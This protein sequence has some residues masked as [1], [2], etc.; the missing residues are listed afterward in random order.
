MTDLQYYED[1]MRG[2]IAINCHTEDEVIELAKWLDNHGTLPLWAKSGS[3]F[4][5][6]FFKEYREHTCYRMQE[7][8]KKLGYADDF[9]YRRMNISVILWSDI[10]SP[11][12]DNFNMSSILDILKE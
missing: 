5:T 4:T 12:D 10:G 2:K 8:S 11:S 9:F 7:H 1:F 6:T 3:L